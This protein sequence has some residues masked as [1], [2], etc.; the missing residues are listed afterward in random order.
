MKWDRQPSSLVIALCVLLGTLSNALA[1]LQS[2]MTTNIPT[3]CFL[4]DSGGLFFFRQGVPAVG[5]NKIAEAMRLRES[6]PA[7]QDPEGH[8]GAVDSGLQLSLRFEK[9][10]YSNGEPVVATILI[11]NVS[12]STIEYVRAYATGRVSPI[13]VLAWHAD[14]PFAL[15]PAPDP[16]R[17][18]MTDIPLFPHSQHKYQVNLGNFYDLNKDG[19]YV[20]QAQYKGLLRKLNRHAELAS[21]SVAV[22][23]RNTP[24]GHE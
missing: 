14:A 13:K 23:V 5:T 7:D 9:S 12:A 16:V 3:N 18:S 6:R 17:A 11:R 4:T 15:K 8:W 20:F 1:Q 21:Q 19:A 24:P 10:T 22:V 2:Q